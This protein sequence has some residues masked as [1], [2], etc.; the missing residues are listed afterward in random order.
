MEDLT[1]VTDRTTPDRLAALRAGIAIMNDAL[2]AAGLGGSRQPPLACALGAHATAASQE[3]SMLRKIRVEDNKENVLKGDAEIFAITTGFGADGQPFVKTQLMPFLAKAKVD[4]TPNM[5]L[6][7]WAECSAPYVNLQLFDKD[8]DVDFHKLAQALVQ[9]VGEG[10]KLSPVT[11][12]FAAVSALGQAVLGAMDS[13][14]FKNNPDHVDSFYVL[15][16]GKTYTDY[17]GASNNA[18]LT[19]EPYTV[20]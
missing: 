19:L 1:H 5:D 9:A 11:A 4:Y 20:G 18:T 13:G 16:R 17:K 10:L 3:L 7:N 15:E 6:V 14:W 12:P 8:G 2:S